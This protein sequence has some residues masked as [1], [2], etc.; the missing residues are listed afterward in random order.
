MTEAERVAAALVDAM[1]E[2]SN[3]TVQFT[4]SKIDMAEYKNRVE[5]CEVKITRSLEYYLR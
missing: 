1:R 4:F 3:A 2:I 5:F